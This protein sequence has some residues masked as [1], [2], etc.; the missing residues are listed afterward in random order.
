M[1]IYTPSIAGLEKISTRRPKYLDP[2][3]AGLLNRSFRRLDRAL[4]IGFLFW[5]YGNPSLWRFMQFEN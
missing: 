1:S 3:V 2:G 5:P 4:G